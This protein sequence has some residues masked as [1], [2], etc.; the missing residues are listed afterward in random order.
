M[1]YL[2]ILINYSL[3][4]MPMPRIPLDM[5]IN[6]KLL[7]INRSFMPAFPVKQRPETQVSCGLYR[8]VLYSGFLLPFAFH[9]NENQDAR[10]S[11]RS[12]NGTEEQRTVVEE[13]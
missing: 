10:K 11:R 5:G 6:K 13:L 12:T 4:L 1:N 3:T 2:Y 9:Q 7:V 8:Y